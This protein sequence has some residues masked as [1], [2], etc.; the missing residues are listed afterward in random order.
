MTRLKGLLAKTGVSYLYKEEFVRNY[1]PD[2]KFIFSAAFFYNYDVHHMQAEHDIAWLWG[3]LQ[4]TIMNPELPTLLAANGDSVLGLS[5]LSQAY[6]HSGD[7]DAD[8]I[9]TL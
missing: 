8:Y 6:T 3:V 5:Y 7:S 9:R 4:T 1:V 2:P